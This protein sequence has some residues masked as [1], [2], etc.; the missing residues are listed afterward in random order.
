MGALARLERRLRQR[1]AR[2]V[3]RD[4]AHETRLENET[5]TESP[6]HGFEH[7]SC[8]LDDL[9]ADT[10]AGKKN[11]VRVHAS[12]ALARPPA[13]VPFGLRAFVRWERRVR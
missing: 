6:G 8:L 5:M 2:F 11:D 10:V 1:L 7:E 4:A 3:D 13:P 9:G 12:A